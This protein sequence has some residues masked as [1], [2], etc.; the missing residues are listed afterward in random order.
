[1]PIDETKL[2]KLTELLKMVNGTLTKEEFVNAFKSLITFIKG[3]KTSL[4]GKFNVLETKINTKVNQL[5]DGADGKD[6]INGKDGIGIKGERGDKGESIQGVNGADGSPD[7][8]D[9]IANKLEVLEGNKRI[10]ISSVKGL[11]TRLN[12]LE[13]R[14][15]GGKAGFGFAYSAMDRHIFDDQTFTG[16]QNGTNKVFTVIK[17]PDPLS[18]L[19]IYR[20]GARLR[21]TEDYTVSKQTVT[22]TVAP[23][24]KEVLLYDLRA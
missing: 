2:K 16:T 15:M 13:E 24:S 5:K 23:A 18:S 12:K 14:P 10:R 7:T 17:A 11:Q 20:G 9:I 8:P 21:I 22:F 4:E 6:G 19:K 1:M 3:V